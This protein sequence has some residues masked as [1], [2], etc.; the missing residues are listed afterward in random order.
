[1]AAN[2]SLLLAIAD[3][4]Q[5]AAL[6]G[7]VLEA[8]GYQVHSADSCTS[9]RQAMREKNP[10]LLLLGDEFP[11]GD[12]FEL[13]E[14]IIAKR[15]DLPIIL[16]AK[17]DSPEKVLRGMRIGLLD[18]LAAPYNP[19]ELIASVERG[20][21]QRQSLERW[22]KKETGRL[23]GT[24]N[25]RLYELEAILKQ[26]D[27]GVLVLDTQK[28]VMMVNQAL[29]TAFGLGDK[30]VLGYSVEELFDNAD[31]LHALERPE[32]ADGQIEIQA[33]D[34]S[35]FVMHTTQITD[36]GTV[37]SL[38]DITYLKE[39]DRL[40]GDFVNAVSHD[41]RSPLTAILGYVEL[42]ERAGEVNE[43]QA[44]FIERVK[45]SVH[46]TTGLIGD[47][48][49]LGRVEVGIIE[50]LEPLQVRELVQ[51]AKETLGTLAEEK[52]ITLR[53]AADDGLSD[54]LGSRTQLR[55]VV[56]NLIGN[57]L[58]YT[59]EGGE[60]R[61]MLREEGGQVILHVADNGPG[62][63][64]EEQKRIFEKFYRAS[65]VDERVEGTGLG[66]AI[67]KT[68][69]DNHRGRIWVDS[70]PGKGAIF[71]VVL[72]VSNKGTAETVRTKKASG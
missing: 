2:R 6:K 24:L 65:N 40:K 59:P 28:R 58:K 5:Y 30:E 52:A 62:I 64:A 63:P 21:K 22:L 35:I 3:A 20:Y 29:R 23:T 72:P 67:V 41:L 1:M 37:A 47:L 68:V 18:Y 39:L 34:G 17:E 11:D 44:Q 61:V 27:D 46:S 51:E 26:V 14:E 53:V 69:V 19:D 16:L 57:A 66:L 12:A 32:E 7:D 8:A 36:V 48:L 9:A 42:I 43:Q 10:P 4:S 33:P 50:D 31:L 71:T 54:V 25:R 49:D 55:Q 13:A 56:D 60:I 70:K 15:P 45:S 38:H